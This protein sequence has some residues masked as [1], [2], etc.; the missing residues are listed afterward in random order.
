[1]SGACV[2][3]IQAVVIATGQVGTT[4]RCLAPSLWP[5]RRHRSLLRAQWT[6][7]YRLYRSLNWWRSLLKY[8]RPLRKPFCDPLGDWY[9]PSCAGINFT[10]WRARW[11]IINFV[12][13]ELGRVEEILRCERPRRRPLWLLAR[14]LND[15]A[16]GMRDVCARICKSTM[17]AWKVVLKFWAERVVFWPWFN[18]YFLVEIIKFCIKRV[19]LIMKLGLNTKCAKLELMV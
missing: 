5:R 3:R 13:C 9:I 10:P 2:E 6:V 18:Y 16:P 8:F 1:M 19:A 11:N 14:G 15:A 4:S 17:F 7:N 12:C